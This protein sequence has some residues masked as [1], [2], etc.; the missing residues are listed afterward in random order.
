LFVD[1]LTTC[2]L[3][4]LNFLKMLQLDASDKSKNFP[5]TA[6]TV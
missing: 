2:W 4:R 6:N 5:G 3:K 1:K